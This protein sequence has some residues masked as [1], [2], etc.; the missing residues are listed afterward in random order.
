VGTFFKWESIIILMPPRKEDLWGL[1][2]ELKK[3]VE[4]KNTIDFTFLTHISPY[5][6]GDVFLTN[7]TL[8]RAIV[9]HERQEGVLGSVGLTV[10]QKTKL[11]R[12]RGFL[13]LGGGKFTRLGL[14][15]RVELI[16]LKDLTKKFP[17]FSLKVGG[18]SMSKQRLRQYCRRNLKPGEIIP[19]KE[20]ISRVEKDIKKGLKTARR[21]RKARRAESQTKA[22]KKPKKRKPR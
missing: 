3:K 12:F 13:P 5:H 14:G 7:E 8:R 22:K 2:I 16:I 1:K 4:G 6:K 10:N 21:K 11:V 20:Y 17:G 9:R 18:K 15:G 19:L